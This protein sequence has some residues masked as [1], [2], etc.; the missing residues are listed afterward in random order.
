MDNL[1]TYQDL[2]NFING[3][4][5]KQLQQPVVIASPYGEFSTY[6]S[7]GRTT[8]SSKSYDKLPLNN[9]ITIESMLYK[10]DNNSNIT[11]NQ[12]KDVIAEMYNEDLQQKIILQ[13]PFDVPPKK[14]FLG[15]L[16]TIFNANSA[17][18]YEFDNLDKEQIVLLSD[19]L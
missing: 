13:Q 12:L 1:E 11:Y 8:E 14:V 5:E 7:L 6:F 16:M 17:G 9:K 3:L 15:Y 19:W 2:L 18:Y 4:N 10:E